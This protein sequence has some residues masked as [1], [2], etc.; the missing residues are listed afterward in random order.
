MIYFLF[1]HTWYL[2]LKSELNSLLIITISTKELNEIEEHI[3]RLEYG[4]FAL[5]QEIFP[6]QN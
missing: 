6:I 3:I 1:N 5:Y 4:L 2:M